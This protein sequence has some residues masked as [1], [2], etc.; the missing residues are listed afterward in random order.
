MG[1][2]LTSSGFG[3]C[4]SQENVCVLTEPI[5][6]LLNSIFKLNKQESAVVLYNALRGYSDIS[7]IVVPG[8]I[9]DKMIGFNKSGQTKVWVNE[10]FGMN[11]PGNHLTEIKLDEVVLLNNLV[12]A[13]SPKLDLSAD[14]LNGVKNSR[15]IGNA[16]NFIR[17]NSGVAESV[18]ENNQISVA[19]FVGTGK[20]QV[21]RDTTPIV[22][23]TVTSGF[24]QPQTQSFVQPQTQSYVQPQVQSYVQPTSTYVPQKAQQANYQPQVGQQVVQSAYRNQTASFVQPQGTSSAFVGTGASFQSSYQVPRYTESINPNKFSF[25]GTQ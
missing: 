7:R 16:L 20:I 3:F 15:T 23:Q 17:A 12:A 13:V 5:P 8:A 19:N 11:H 25:N 14:F 4:G 18:L 21:L 1:A 9:T 24:V 2:N 22:P 10:N 6:T